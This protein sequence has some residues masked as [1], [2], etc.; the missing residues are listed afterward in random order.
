MSEESSLQYDINRIRDVASIVSQA[1][2]N[3]NKAQ[4]TIASIQEVE[5][6]KGIKN[7][8]CVIQSIANGASS[9]VGRLQS[10]ISEIQE[11]EKKNEIEIE[12][13]DGQLVKRI[14]DFIFIINE[15]SYDIEY[16]DE[17]YRGNGVGGRIFIPTTA[18]N[19]EPVTV[20]FLFPGIEVQDMVYQTTQALNDAQLKDNEIVIAV[21]YGG[22]ADSIINT[23]NELSEKYNISGLNITGFSLS[24]R[25]VVPLTQELN[26]KGCHVDSLDIIS[27]CT[28]DDTDNF[29]EIMDSGTKITGY[30]GPSQGAD[31]GY[32][33]MT[34]YTDIFPVYILEGNHSYSGVFSTYLKDEV[35]GKRQYANVK[36]IDEKSEKLENLENL[37]KVDLPEFKRV[38]YLE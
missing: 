24:G 34:K 27:A 12:M 25:S 31:A 18:Q 7:K 6:I 20:R 37:E 4:T 22:S 35:N 1:K 23:V 2:Q 29:Y 3:L 32:N 28:T 9:I 30:V 26:G 33:V 10:Y 17:L 36:V 5:E 13:I 15:F 14:G 11:L 21:T 8:A 16:V 38:H 19:G